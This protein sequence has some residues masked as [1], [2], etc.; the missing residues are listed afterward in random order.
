MIALDTNALVRILVE[1]DEKQARAVRDII[2]DC[3][4]HS[5]RIM[6]LAEVLIETV[7]VLESAYGCSRHEIHHFLETLIKA[8]LFVFSDP[9]VINTAI[10][11]YK[12]GGD[13]A[14]LIIVSQAKRLQAKNLIS[15]DRKLQNR[16]PGFVVQSIEI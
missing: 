13:F 16:F 2:A 7:W 4:A 11:Q 1:D 8:P 6:I 15:F 10:S 9:F 5:R 3:E 12:K 14:D